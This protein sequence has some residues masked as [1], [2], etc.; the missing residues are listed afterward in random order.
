MVDV[1]QAQE[2]Q[3]LLVPF[4]RPTRQYI[5]AKRSSS[6][7]DKRTAQ[8]FQVLR[9]TILFCW[10][11]HQAMHPTFHTLLYRQKILKVPMMTNRSSNYQCLG[12][13]K[14]EIQVVMVP[15]HLS[16]VLP[17]LTQFFHLNCW[18]HC[19]RK[20]LWPISERMDWQRLF[21]AR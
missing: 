10:R 16:V 17:G 8:T 4:A 15:H 7:S 13:V 21:V 19:P 2:R 20:K 12:L 6:A 14:S 3:S 18:Q 11:H 5:M 1:L 9:C